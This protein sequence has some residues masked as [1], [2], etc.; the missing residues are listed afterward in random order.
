ML[1]HGSGVSLPGTSVVLL[2]ET[3]E[4][5]LES[6][7]RKLPHIGR[8]WRDPAARSLL[9]VLFEVPGQEPEEKEALHWGTGGRALGASNC[10]AT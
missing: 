10:E 3:P 8:T 5:A 7:P 9:K 2:P 6:P 4:G 1:A